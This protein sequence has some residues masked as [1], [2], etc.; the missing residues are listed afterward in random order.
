MRVPLFE[1]Q[2]QAAML[3]M[4]DCFPLAR[5]DKL[6][7]FAAS[8]SFEL[9]GCH[10]S[11]RWRHSHLS[12]DIGSVQRACARSCC[13]C[14]NWMLATVI[15]LDY[16]LLRLVYF[17]ATVHSESSVRGERFICNNNDTTEYYVTRVT[18]FSLTYLTDQR[19]QA[20][21]YLCRRERKTQVARLSSGHNAGSTAAARPR[22]QTSETTTTTT[23]ASAPRND[24]FVQNRQQPIGEASTGET[25]REPVQRCQ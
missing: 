9:L 13:C 15:A 22:Q 2:F 6:H 23:T 20:V 7:V 11:L 8:S 21:S 16:W 25:E 12:A 17:R 14:C 19:Q 4:S 5:H 10:A 1:R 24:R 3:S 18:S